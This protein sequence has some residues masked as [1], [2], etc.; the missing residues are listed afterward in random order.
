M[1]VDPGGGVLVA[2]RYTVEAVHS[3]VIPQG[4][5]GRETW[6]A[7]D[8]RR[9]KGREEIT[10]WMQSSKLQ[11]RAA[12]NADWLARLRGKAREGWSVKG[13]NCECSDSPA[14]GHGLRGAVLGWYLPVLVVIE[15][16][17]WSVGV[18]PKLL[19]KKVAV[20]RAAGGLEPAVG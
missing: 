9:G 17:R 10:G 14:A 16:Q 6:L 19:M 8:L 2:G 11:R 7:V 5:A 1:S 18:R 20:D 15:G 12:G 3:Q 13:H 4:L